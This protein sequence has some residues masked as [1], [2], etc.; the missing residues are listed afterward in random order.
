M[1][2]NQMF[3]LDQDPKIPRH[4]SSKFLAILVQRENSLIPYF[5]LNNIKPLPFSFMCTPSVMVRLFCL[6]FMQP[7]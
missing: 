1:G 6:L 2:G 7:H 4:L 5:N 3:C